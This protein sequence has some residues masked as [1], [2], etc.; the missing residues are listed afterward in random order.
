L[1]WEIKIY[2][3]NRVQIVR[4]RN[5]DKPEIRSSVRQLLTPDS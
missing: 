1:W 4:T 2:R 3:L 5:I